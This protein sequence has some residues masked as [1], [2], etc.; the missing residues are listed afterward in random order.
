MPT[1][2]E[3]IFSVAVIIRPSSLGVVRG[4]E[5]IHSK[6]PLRRHGRVSEIIG[7]CLVSWHKLRIVAFAHNM[8]AT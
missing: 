3:F 6:P 7:L 2:R 8:Y 4:A 1:P 5:S